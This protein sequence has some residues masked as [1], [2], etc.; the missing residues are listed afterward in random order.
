MKKHTIIG[1]KILSEAERFPVIDAGSIIAMQHHEKWDG[2]G[3]P[4]GL[5][6][7]NIHVFAR[8]VTIVDIFDALSSVRPYKKAFPLDVALNIM[9]EGRGVFFDPSLLD[10]FLK[11]IDSFVAIRE[12]LQDDPEELENVFDMGKLT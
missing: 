6:G 11:N 9:E 12:K 1:G 8:I 2:S 5:N 10:L 3:Y 4:S 7:E